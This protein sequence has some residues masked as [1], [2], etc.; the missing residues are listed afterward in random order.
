MRMK[1]GATSLALLTVLTVGACGGQALETNQGPD[2]SSGQ[3]AGAG[4]EAA[5]GDDARVEHEAGATTQSDDGGGA[6]VAAPDGGAAPDGAIVVPR[7]HR[8]D[9]AQCRTPR[10]AGTCSSGAGPGLTCSSDSDCTDGGA[11]GRCLTN[12]G[13]PAGCFCSYDGCQSD[14]DC[15]ASQ[16]CACHGSP[17][18]YGGNTCMASTCRVD[19]DCGVGG[20]CS[21]SQGPNNC[22]DL[23]GYYC[24]TPDDACTNDTDCIGGGN[25]ACMWST[26]DRRW[27][28]M[29]IN[30]LTCPV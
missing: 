27:K 5:A 10:R 12:G 20:Y 23:V 21:P 14:A 15:G 4:A 1:L 13:G 17:Y 7:N 11:D 18:L 3:E 29:A 2:A 22:D 24:H 30:E 8:A 25:Q 6:D 28:C 9:D 19:A 26:S 16:V